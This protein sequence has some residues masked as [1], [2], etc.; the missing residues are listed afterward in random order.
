V[1]DPADDP[2]ALYKEILDTTRR[3]SLKLSEGERKR[4]IELAAEIRDADR[5]IKAATEKE[6]QASQEITAWWREVAARMTGLT[7][8]TPGRPPEPDPEARAKLLDDYMA[9]IQP[10]TNALIAAL[11]RASW[12][13]R[14]T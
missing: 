6:T 11:R 1:T 13:R 14:S 7:W 8:I 3:A 12:P 10:R 9:E 2:V 4:T 5:A